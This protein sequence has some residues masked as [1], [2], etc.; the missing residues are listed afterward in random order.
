MVLI[1]DSGN[2]VGEGVKG[3][4]VVGEKEEAAMAAAEAVG[5]WADNLRHYNPPV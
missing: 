1:R 5:F 4:G 2:D 3:E